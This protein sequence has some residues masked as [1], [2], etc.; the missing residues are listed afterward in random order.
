MHNRK[1]T[2]LE[3]FCLSY[4]FA[5]FPFFPLLIYIVFKSLILG[6]SITES[7]GL[8][9]TCTH[10][11]FIHFSSQLPVYV[12]ESPFRMR[13]LSAEPN[14]FR[15]VAGI[16]KYLLYKHMMC[17]TDSQ[18]LRTNNTLSTIFVSLVVL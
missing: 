4:S 9:L 8:L 16:S 5:I 1:N 6:Y 12:A 14:V 2:L 15:E 10:T 3:N 17:Q 11:Q 13:R 7:C 18:T